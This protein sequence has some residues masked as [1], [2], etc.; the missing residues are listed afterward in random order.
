MTR[1]EWGP[2]AVTYP[3]WQGTAQIDEKL[4]GDVDMYSLAGIDRDEW[5]IIG[6]EFG[7]GESGWHELHL[8][9]VPHGTN[10]DADHI[11]ATDLLIHDVNPVDFLR[12]VLHSADFRF[13]SQGMAGKTITVTALGDVPE[14]D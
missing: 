3:D 6:L 7:G 10:L 1:Y 11:E 14:Q 8:I 13:R 5:T 12:Q 2:A 4:T 9:A